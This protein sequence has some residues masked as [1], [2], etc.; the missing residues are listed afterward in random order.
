MCR[1]YLFSPWCKTLYTPL[2]KIH[3]RTNKLST[4]TQRNRR[5]FVQQKLIYL[6]VR[7]LSISDFRSCIFYYISYELIELNVFERVFASKFVTHWTHFVPLKL[8]P[9]YILNVYDIY[10]YITTNYL[11]TLKL[12]TYIS[13]KIVNWKICDV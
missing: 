12:W 10:L 9:I 7:D 6:S 5:V 4:T 2:M 11:S 8:S 3:F 1:W 13:T